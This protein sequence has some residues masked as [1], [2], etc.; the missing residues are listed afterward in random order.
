MD[1]SAKTYTKEDMQAHWYRS[2]AYTAEMWNKAFAI[3]PG[4]VLYG[5]WNDMYQEP[6]HNH[7]IFHDAS[8][9]DDFITSLAYKGSVR[10][11]RSE[12]VQRRRG[13]FITDQHPDGH[14]TAGG[15]F[16]IAAR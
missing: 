7:V 2:P 9:E 15:E 8:L 6:P 5:S 11:A 10:R 13:V 1:A 16:W 14:P 4:G 3:P 12:G